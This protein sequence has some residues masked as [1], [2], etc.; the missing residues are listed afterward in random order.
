ML[1]PGM[2]VDKFRAALGPKINGAQ[3][4]HNALQGHDLDFFVVTSSISAT[5]GQPG[6]SN[7]G[8]A[9]SFLDNF[10]WQRNL[11]GLPATSL[12]L[13]MVLGVGVVAENN[14]LE[15]KIT[16]RGMHRRA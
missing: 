8:A 14:S 6:Q 13:P 11:K 10:A 9:N 4:L 2:S 15:E 1:G 5:I 3:V 16:R 12:V 7:Y